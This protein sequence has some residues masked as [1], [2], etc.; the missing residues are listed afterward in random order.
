[1]YHLAYSQ[2][3]M[4]KE[5]VEKLLRHGAYDIFSEDKLG[6]SEKESTD[7]MAQ[8]IDSIL[9]RRSKTVIHDNTGSKS[10]ACG[11]TFSKASYKASK[12][13][14]DTS[15][16]T[17]EDVDIDDPEFWTKMIGETGLDD[18]DTDL[19]GKKRSRKK[20]NYSETF[21]DDSLNATI[22]ND[23]NIDVNA[24]DQFSLSDSDNELDVDKCKTDED[25]FNCG[26]NSVLKNP[27]LQSLK[28]KKI[29]YDTSIERPHWGGRL[30]SEWNKCDA[31]IL[32]KIL[33]K[34][35]YGHAN[36]QEMFLKVKPDLSKSYEYIE[37][38]S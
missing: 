4:T 36:W 2:K 37:V 33:L 11:G 25:V 34:S 10:N 14:N 32:L 23:N 21:F 1:M 15:K 5:E 30:I 31:A 16:E 8:D 28:E 7:F 12:V 22:S 18:V 6:E 29:A 3:T 35:G 17:V 27:V 20:T 13:L 24:S 26:S 38:S 9:E 19:S